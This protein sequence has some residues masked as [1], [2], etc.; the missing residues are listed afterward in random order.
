MPVSPP[1]SLS[2]ARSY[3]TTIKPSRLVRVQVNGGFVEVPYGAPVGA[4]LQDLPVDSGLTVLA[5]MVHHRCVD[6]THPICAPTDVRPVT[7]AHR[8]GVLVY[9]RSV[10]L[11]LLE[12]AREVVA[13]EP[14]ARFVL[15]GEG[16][17]RAELERTASDLG[18]GD[19]FRFL[20]YRS[21][22]PRVI[23]ALDVYVLSSLWEGLP[24]AL[25]EAL[26]MGKPV[27]ATRVGGNPE[28]VDHGVNGFIVP[29]RDA[30]ALAQ[31]LLKT[32]RDDAFRRN[33]RDVNRTRFETQ[34]SLQA[35]VSAHE[36]LY[37]EVARTRRLFGR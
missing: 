31:A 30:S 20:G 24:L 14:R 12:A 25:L 28:V 34:F 9:R 1:S 18:L 36:K 33:A 6:L 7:Y 13:K 4:V 5:A 27:V 10:S 23:S 32:C 29:P 15:A 2:F 3:P 17:L 26:A 37:V 21:D 16:P 35:M 11:L 8:E 22:M 19:R